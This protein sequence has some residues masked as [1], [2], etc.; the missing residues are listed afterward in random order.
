[1]SEPERIEQAPSNE[2]TL[3]GTG[4]GLGAYR[5]LRRLGF[6]GMGQVFAAR[7]EDGKEIV[8]LKQ[9]AIVDPTLLYRFK[10]EFRS[11]ADLSHPNLVRLGELVVLPTG[12]AFYTM[13]LVEGQNLVRWVRRG[14]PAGMVPN[15]HRL[16]HA[17][18]QLAAGVAHLHRGARVHRDLKP[19]NISVTDEG[20]VVILDFGLV[21]EV[22]DGD[23]RITATGQLVG[24]PAY[25]AP[26]QGSRSATEPAIDLYAIGVTLF[27][28][29]TGCM[30]FIG[31]ALRV[32]LSKQHAPAPDPRELAEG[33]PDWLA[34]L[35]RSLLDVEP[36]L[37]PTAE[38]VIA[39]LDE[40]VAATPV[41]VE[42]DESP[43]PQLLGRDQE[44]AVL[45][46]A[47]EQVASQGLATVVRLTGP[48]GRGKSALVD[49][50]LQSVRGFKSVVLRGR[51]HPRESMPYKGVD[52]VIDALAVYLRSLPEVEAAALRP[53]H[54]RELSELFPVLGG[55]WAEPGRRVAEHEPVARRRFGLAAL[56]EILARIGDEATLLVVIDDFEWADLD[57]FVVLSE[58]LLPPETPPLLLI[59]A[60]DASVAN[61]VVVRAKQIDA[62]RGARVIELDLPPLAEAD[63]QALARMLIDPRQVDDVDAYARQLARESGGE[64]LVVVRGATAAA[65]LNVSVLAD[66]EVLR[67]IR[68][69]AAEPCAVLT[70]ATVAGDRLA[71]ELARTVLGLD[72]GAFER[73]ARE[74]V[75]AGLLAQ[76]A[77]ESGGVIKLARP[78]IGE[79]VR[80][81]IDADREAQLHASLAEALAENH[82]EAELVAAHFEA[83]GDTERAR[84]YMIAAAR[85]AADALAFVRAEQLYRRALVLHLEH[86]GGEVD[87]DGLALKQALADQLTN[88]ARSPEAAELYVEVANHSPPAKAATLRLRAAEQYAVSGWSKLALGL[89]R[90]LL[91]EAGEPLP[92][93]M[94][95]ALLMFA[96]NRWQLARRS[97]REWRRAASDIS[98]EAIDR[99][100]LVHAALLALSRSEMILGIALTPRTALL[101]LEAGDPTR[102]VISRMI[103]TTFLI[104]AGRFGTARRNLSEIEAIAEQADD[105]LARAY[106]HVGWHHFH[107]RRAE[108]EQADSHFARAMSSLGQLRR[109]DWM[110]G[111]ALHIQ[112]LTLR[113]SGAYERLASSLP[114]WIDLIH[115]HGQHQTA[116]LLIV[117]DVLVLAQRGETQLAR[118]SFERGRAWWNVDYYNF[119]D[120][121]R[122]IAEV[123]LLLAEGRTAEAC[124]VG[125]R[126]SE[127]LREHG[128]ARLKLPR[129]RVLETYLLARTIHATVA[130]DLR[131][132]SLTRELR[133]LRRSRVPFFSTTALILSAGWASLFGDHQRERELYRQ[134]IHECDATS[135]H[136][137]AAAAR[138]RL[139]ALEVEDAVQLRAA[140]NAY[141]ER[142]KIADVRRFVDLMAPTR[143]RQQV[144]RLGPG[145]T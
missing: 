75:D 65:P 130:G 119:V 4:F 37:R 42:V 12:L 78:R 3:P 136:A 40:H 84:A 22:G 1:M 66:D 10:Q 53:R 88:L 39:V 124:E 132:A 82:A 8:A 68:A 17:M 112:A 143:A 117:E 134:A 55:I 101:A 21:F 116:A 6:G 71:N 96:R 107:A 25:M 86:S 57:G 113:Q 13:E 62:L 140:A 111:S 38:Q 125:R 131:D 27:E 106:V 44:F 105:L 87:A 28:C 89:L 15:V 100:D 29:L 7:R 9:I 126:T 50:F 49:H 32:L 20:R 63:V 128:H 36:S 64:P 97:R 41:S 138:L 60:Y 120:Y 61:P 46:R 34:Q 45:E 93:S 76:I 114:A 2:V 69:L 145:Q 85:E 19:A 98:P 77:L 127:Q 81:E 102:V 99:F 121:L 47:Y 95:G 83:G 70:L 91:L 43:G 26:E 14:T 16:C 31:T 58:L 18:R 79:L 122:G 92:T 129:T 56:R 103:M 35:C 139:A 144:S 51:C 110:K 142:E 67:H 133:R 94:F 118:R 137:Y 52:S 90:E 5:I 30:P 108:L 123:W 48:P 74:L 59:L 24:T 73:A 115:S 23:P 109:E 11:L 54:L 104:T 141:F 72:A 80:V 33:I 135:M